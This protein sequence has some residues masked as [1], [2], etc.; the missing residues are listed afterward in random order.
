[1]YSFHEHVVET[2]RDAVVLQ[3]VMSG[4]FSLCSLSFQ[5][6]SKFV[7]QVLPPTIRSQML[8]TGTALVL[9]PC[10]VLMIDVESI[11]FHCHEM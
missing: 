5:M 7:A 8:D 6:M 9:C 1:M 10:L 3:G 2:L 4:E 11:R